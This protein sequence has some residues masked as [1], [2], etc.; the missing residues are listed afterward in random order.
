M[1]SFDAIRIAFQIALASFVSYLLGF[2]FTDLFHAE[3]ASIGGLWAAISSIVVLQA[4]RHD[5]WSSAL[6]R[7]IGTA[8]GAVISAA[9]LIV[10]PFN[11]FGIAV[12]IFVAVLLC[13][14]IRVPDHARLAAST[15]AVVIVT[16]S[17]HP[18]LDPIVNAALRLSESFIGTVMAV[19]MVLI[20]RGPKEPSNVA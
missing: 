7:V 8:I 11:P 6:L 2:Y 1:I 19:L 5:T 4:S 10:L 9:Y 12:S 13:H 17:I 18:A 20:W 15:V 16:A 3:S 14:A